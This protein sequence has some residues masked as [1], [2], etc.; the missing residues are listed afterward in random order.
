ML[1]EA[2]IKT[3]Q[4]ITVFMAS[5]IGDTVVYIPSLQMLRAMYPDAT[6]C[7]ICNQT[8]L[9][10]YRQFNF[11]DRYCLF[12][13]DTDI[14]SKELNGE[15][16]NYLTANEIKEHDNVTLPSLHEL[17]QDNWGVTD[18]LIMTE[19]NG[20]YIKAALES[21][22]RQVLTFCYSRALYTSRLPF[23]RYFSRHTHHEVFSLQFLLKTLDKKRFKEVF[24]TTDLKGA[25][26]RA[27]A[28]ARDSINTFLH[29]SGYLVKSSD[30]LTGF[31]PYRRPLSIANS[32]Q[33]ELNEAHVGQNIATYRYLIVINPN[34]ISTMG[35][36]YSYAPEC[37]VKMARDLAESFPHILFVISSY[38]EQSYHHEEYNSPNLKLYINEDGLM[39]VIALL[40][41]CDLLISP[42][43]GPAHI[44]DNIGRDVLGGYAYYDEHRWAA[45]GLMQLASKQK[46][47]SIT[48][49]KFAMHLIK[50]K[51]TNGLGGDF[52][53]FHSMCKEYIE[54]NF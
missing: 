15:N 30:P 41:Q 14:L 7:Y 2:L 37:Y 29:D 48:P 38:G 31:V 36:G 6:I 26:L 33:P 45:I 34:S 10:L 19:R 39:N 52:E 25:V 32:S 8:A 27:S 12:T 53:K 54:A 3:P 24:D 51:L 47:P 42:S 43:T 22:C 4:R 1:C 44:A 21:S 20:K 28:H 9:T 35:K 40:E 17:Q 46:K 5:G 18:L 11:A 23:I 13:G 49:H 16:L 50:N